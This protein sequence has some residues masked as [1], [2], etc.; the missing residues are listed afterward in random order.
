MEDALRAKKIKIRKI[1]GSQAD[2]KEER[3]ALFAVSNKRG[4]C[5]F[6]CLIKTLI[7][8]VIMMHLP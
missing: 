4:K 3:D 6:A 8:I 7:C 5:A 1:D 2:T